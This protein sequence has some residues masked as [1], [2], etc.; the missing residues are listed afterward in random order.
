[1][2][3]LSNC[4]FSL[5]QVWING[6]DTSFPSIYNNGSSLAIALCHTCTY[7]FKERDG[8]MKIF[9]LI[10][11]CLFIFTSRSQG[12]SWKQE[13]RLDL[14]QS[15]GLVPRDQLRRTRRG[16]VEDSLLYIP[17]QNR[18]VS[19]KCPDEKDATAVNIS[20]LLLLT[21]VLTISSLVINI[22]NNVNN[23]NNNN[24]RNSINAN[25]NNNL[26]SNTNVNNGNQ[27]N[28]M[29]PVLNP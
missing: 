2:V 1:M 20:Q 15:L 14:L 4:L 27:I 13:L 6:V 24:N 25:S 5:G 17:I 7:Q 11:A 29:V 22:S 8:I 16:V 28:V 3:C 9:S 18:R 10:L 26:V 12:T 19:V 21:T 23:N